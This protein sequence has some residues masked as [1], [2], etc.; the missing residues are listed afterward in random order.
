MFVVL[1][2]CRAGDIAKEDIVRGSPSPTPGDPA[3]DPF[4]FTPPLSLSESRVSRGGVLGEE[5]WVSYSA[6]SYSA[7]SNG[8]PFFIDTRPLDEGGE[9]QVCTPEAKLHGAGHKTHTLGKGRVCL[10]GSLRGWDL[11]Q[12]LFQCDSWARGWEI[13]KQTG[14]FPDSPRDSCSTTARSKPSRPTSFLR[15]LF[16]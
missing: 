1:L 15:R 12:I 2:S 10:A 13:F 4:S 8:M 3:F 14:R 16:S 7:P 5:I 11:T 6:P 9:P